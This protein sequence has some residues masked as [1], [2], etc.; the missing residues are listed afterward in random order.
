MVEHTAPVQ[1]Y[2][3]GIDGSEASEDAF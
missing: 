2:F 1:N 3:V